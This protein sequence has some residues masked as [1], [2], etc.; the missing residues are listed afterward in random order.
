M[1]D[2]SPVW[3][4]IPNQ[5]NITEGIRVGS[6]LQDVDIKASDSDDGENGLVVYKIAEKDTPFSISNITGILSVERELDRE[7]K[8]RFE[9]TVIAADCGH[10][11]LKTMHKILVIVMDENIWSL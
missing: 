11:S 4:N 3:I 9:L 10:P 7:Q 6:Q 2:N 5:I 8:D 1:N